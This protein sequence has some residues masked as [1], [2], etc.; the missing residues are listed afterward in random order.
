MSNGLTMPD[1]R[2]YERE[3]EFMPYRDS[4]VAV[5]AYV[6]KV[7]PENG[8]VLDLM[9]GPGFLLGVLAMRRPDLKLTG[10][11]IDQRY[12]DYARKK[13]PRVRFEQKNILDWQTDERFDGV[14]CTG[15][16]HHIPYGQQEKALERMASFS[17]PEGLV[18]LSDCYV[19][20]YSNGRERKLAAAELGYEY[21]R[22]TI[23]NNA[24]DDVIQATADIIANDVLTREFKTSLA[25]RLESIERFF[26][27]EGT[28]KTWPA[29][30]TRYG[31]Y[32]HFLSLKDSPKQC[33]RVIA[34]ERTR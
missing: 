8:N 16:L 12:I 6:I 18:V 22:A 25:K 21:L 9:C 32:V 1:P 23:E 17:T 5:A 10:V 4:L 7:A 14:L 20:D 34:A 3:L 2:T 33:L 13:Y 28:I 26:Q 24:P 27:I 15:A 31:D 29:Y 11:D 19:N 30:P